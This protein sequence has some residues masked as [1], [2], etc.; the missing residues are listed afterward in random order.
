[1]NILKKEM[2]MKALPLLAAC[3][4]F[5]TAMYAQNQ[6][7]SFK[8]TYMMSMPAQ[9]AISSSDG[10]IDVVP[11]EGSEIE[12]F[13]IVKRDD[14]ILKIDRKA[15][16]KELTV[17]VVH[18]GSNLKINVK[19]PQD[20][21]RGVF[22]NRM[23]V[24]FEIRAPRETACTLHTSDG[25]ISLAGLNGDQEL[26]TSDGNIRIS[27]AAGNVT[28]KSS[29]GDVS[30]DGIKGS[31]EAHTSDGNIEASNIVGDIM[32]STSDG[33]ITISKAEG[34]TSLKTSD[35]HITF[36]ELTGSFSGVTSDGNIRGS[37]VQ[38]KKE[39][40]ARTGDGNIDITLPDRL[41]LDLDIKGESLHVPLTGFSGRSDDDVIRGKANG[42]GIPVSLSTSDGSV[43]LAYR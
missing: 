10:N 6:E 26:K 19:Y 34:N 24:S 40:V 15:L 16:E 36:K 13:Y 30:L 1:V 25:N 14:S 42:G 18:D 20:Y 11:S 29:D 37:F 38:L 21:M 28:G 32:A 9:L 27:N 22:R 41:G 17:E 33:N 5:A 8:E 35:G 4:V 7:Y 3:M 43:T 2:N 23:Y 12:V 39:L 31:V